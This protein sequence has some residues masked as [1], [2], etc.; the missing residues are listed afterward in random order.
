MSHTKVAVIMGGTSTEHE[1]SL[2]SGAGIINNLDYGSYRACPI[3]ISKAGRWHC[4]EDYRAG[5][6]SV[7]PAGGQ[8]A[9]R[10]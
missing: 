8:T 2:K 5:T 1:V 9:S 4:A 3:V 6:G 10:R 7:P